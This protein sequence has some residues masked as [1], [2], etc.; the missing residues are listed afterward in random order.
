[1]SLQQLL[2]AEYLFTGLVVLLVV[3]A[4]IGAMVDHLGDR[5]RNRRL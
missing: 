4:G 2:S 5:R 1:V 3:G